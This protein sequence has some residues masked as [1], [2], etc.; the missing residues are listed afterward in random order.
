MA[1]WLDVT[2]RFFDEDTDKELEDNELQEE[3]EAFQVLI[4]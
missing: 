1:L 3:V 4:E 2:S